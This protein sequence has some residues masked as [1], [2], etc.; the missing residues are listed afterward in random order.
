MVDFWK[1]FYDKQKVH[2]PRIGSEISGPTFRLCGH[3]SLRI[4]PHPTSHIPQKMQTYSK[5]HSASINFHLFPMFFFEKKVLQ[6]TSK[7]ISFNVIVPLLH[8]SSHPSHL[9]ILLSCDICCQLVDVRI[10]LRS[11][12]R[13]QWKFTWIQ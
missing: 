12:P 7:I 11:L 3:L 5:L 13:F 9:C 10:Q 4:P 1:P 8:P 2:D 6:A